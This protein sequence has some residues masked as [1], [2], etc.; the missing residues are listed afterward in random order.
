[1]EPVEIIAIGNKIE[2]YRVNNASICI[3]IHIE[4][5]LYT[6]CVVMCTY[7][8]MSFFFPGNSDLI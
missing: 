1:M 8:I 3:H 5:F 7:Y 4:V 2:W 6:F